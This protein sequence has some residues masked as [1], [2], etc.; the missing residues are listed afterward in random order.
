MNNKMNLVLE[1]EGNAHILYSYGGMENYLNRVLV[2]IQDGI[3]AG[4]Y[5]VL[6]ENSRLYPMIQQEL[7]TQLT[8][9]EMKLLHFVNSIDFYY[10]SGSYHPPAIAEYFTKTIQPYLGNKISFRA[11]AH[12]EWATMEEPLHLIE[13]LEKIVDEAVNELSLTLI[14]AYNGDKMPDYVKTFLLETHQYLLLEDDFIVSEQ[15][16]PANNL[17]K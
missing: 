12:V 7:S 6:I 11:W 17:V 4:E 2:Y 8:E 15:Y 5:V 9:D 16:Q 14:C 13:D 1:N 10:S 3:A